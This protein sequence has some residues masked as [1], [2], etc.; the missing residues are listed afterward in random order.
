MIIRFP[1]FVLRFAQH[2]HFLKFTY[3]W[4]FQWL[5]CSERRWPIET[6]TCSFPHKCVHTKAKYPQ[7]SDASDTCCFYLN[8]TFCSSLLIWMLYKD[9]LDNSL[10]PFCSCVQ[11]KGGQSFDLF[12]MCHILLYHQLP[13]LCCS[14]RVMSGNTSVV[15]LTVENFHT[16]S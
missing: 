3:S 5:F 1:A 10:F 9:M 6:T 8:W 16:Q 12:H 15:W 4:T 13:L 2:L 7:K 11:P 14:F